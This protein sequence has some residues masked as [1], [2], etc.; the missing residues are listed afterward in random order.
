MR[1][2]F[3]IN[4]TEE[5]NKYVENL[6]DEYDIMGNESDPVR[7][8]LKMKE[9]RPDFLVLDIDALGDCVESVVNYLGDNDLSDIIILYSDSAETNMPNGV[10]NIADGFISSASN[11]KSIVP[12][13]QMAKARKQQFKELESEYIE[14]KKKL[15]NSKIDEISSHKLKELYH[16]SELETENYLGLLNSE[17]PDQKDE[18]KTIVYKLFN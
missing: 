10:M 12:T 11:P 5:Y 4:R 8:V 15:Q 17:F 1:V 13:F 9:N 14:L 3:S 6:N 16:F 18:I 2:L 7:L